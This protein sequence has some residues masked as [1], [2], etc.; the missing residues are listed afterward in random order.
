MGVRSI[1][2]EYNP[3][4][5]EAR[6]HVVQPGDVMGLRRNGEPALGFRTTSLVNLASSDQSRRDC[7]RNTPRFARPSGGGLACNVRW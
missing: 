7:N 5:T 4:P 3:T 6:S 2:D 1:A